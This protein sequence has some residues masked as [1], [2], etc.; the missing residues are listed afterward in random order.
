M[1]GLVDESNARTADIH[2]VADFGEKREK[3]CAVLYFNRFAKE[4]TPLVLYLRILSF[5]RRQGER[6]RGVSGE[7][8]KV[9]LTPEYEQKYSIIS[10]IFLE[11]SKNFLISTKSP[12]RSGKFI[13]AFSGN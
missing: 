7:S 13:G 6:V 1:S 2:V 9:H 4:N 5:D 11:N 8:F 3:F 10:Y 12:N